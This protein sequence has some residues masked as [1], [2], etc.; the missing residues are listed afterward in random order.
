MVAESY[1][2]INRSTVICFENVVSYDY[3]IIAKGPKSFQNIILYF[4]KLLKETEDIQTPGL[5]TL[6]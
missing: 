3:S 2:N 6:C 5:Y 1:V 4:K